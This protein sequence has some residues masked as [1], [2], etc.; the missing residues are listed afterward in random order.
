MIRNIQIED[1][2]D[3][4][5]ICKKSLG[6]ETTSELL[7]RRIEE[8]S[9]NSNYR[10]LVYEDDIEHQVL[11]FIQAERYNLLYGGNGWNIIALAV[12]PAAQQNGI[13][14]QLLAAME[15]QAEKEGYTFIRLNCNTI[16][17]NAHMFYQSMGYSCDKIQK[18]F[19]KMIE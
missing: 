15:D 7:K 12:L 6:Y 9:N 17:E 2:Q 11:G 16:R 5:H 10:F 1:A 4:E 3:L 14:K 8:L 13:G 19:I 18:R